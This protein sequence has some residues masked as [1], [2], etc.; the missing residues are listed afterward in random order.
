MPTV[1]H[2]G[3]SGLKWGFMS[4]KGV[5]EI[6]FINGTMNA[7]LDTQTLNDKM[8]PILKKKFLKKENHVLSKYVH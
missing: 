1:K 2:G 4:A 5:R 3:E 7:S 8:T 6:T